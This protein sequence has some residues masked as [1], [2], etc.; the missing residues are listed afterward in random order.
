ML[1]FKY[2][3]IQ[4]LFMIFKS[5]LN[6]K[7]ILFTLLIFFII[8]IAFVS[9]S[10]AFSGAGSGTTGDP[11]QITDRAQLE[12]ISDNLSASYILMNDIDLGGSATPW[13]SISGSFS[14]IIDGNGMSI[15]N[16][17]SNTGG[18][19]V[20]VS[21]N[22]INLALINIEILSSSHNI[23]GI[24]NSPNGGIFENC[25]VIG[26]LSS[27]YIESMPMAGGIC[28]STEIGNVTINNCWTNVDINGY[29]CG[30]LLGSEGWG[31]PAIISNCYALGNIS[32]GNSGGAPGNGG[33]I[34]RADVNGITVSN[35]VSL[36]TSSSAT[37]TDTIGRIGYKVEPAAFTNNY[38]S[39]IQLV[40]GVL[41]SSSDATSNNG[42]DVTPLQ[43]ATKSWW[44]TNPGWS[45]DDNSSWYWN[46][47]SNLPDLRIFGH[48]PQIITFPVSPTVDTILLTGINY[49]F[50][51][52]TIYADTFLWDFGD[53]IT[54]SDEN[55]SH[56]YNNVGNYNVTLTVSN[57]IGNAIAYHIYAVID[58]S[59]ITNQ[60]ATLLQTEQVTLNTYSTQRYNPYQQYALT[61]NVLDIKYTTSSDA[62]FVSGTTPYYLDAKTGIITP[63]SNYV[64]TTAELCYID[65]YGIAIYDT[66][67]VISYYSYAT[68]SRQIIAVVDNVRNVT[69]GKTF[70]PDAIV[71]AYTTDINTYYY[72]LDTGITYTSSS[73][74][75]GIVGS[76]SAKTFLSWNNTNPSNITITNLVYTTL[77][78]NSTNQIALTAGTTI[79]SIQS[80]R[81][82]DNFIVRTTDKIFV[83]E[84]PT[85]NLISTSAGGMP[86]FS[87]VR[88]DQQLEYMGLNETSAYFVN[89]VG[90]LVTYYTGIAQLNTLAISSES[91]IWSAF[92]GDDMRLT[93]L[94]RSSP[95]TWN[96]SEQIYFS[97]SINKVVL[98]TGGYYLTVVSDG[99]LYLLSQATP[100]SSDT[101]LTTKYYLQVYLIDGGQ[102]LGNTRFTVAIGANAPVTYT[103]DSSGSAVVEVVPTRTYTIAFYDGS[104]LT[105]YTANNYALQYLI[106]SK[107][108]GIPFVNGI[109]Y[110]VSLDYKTVYMTYTDTDLRNNMVNFTISNV[111][112]VLQTYESV[113][114]SVSY[115]YDATSISDNYIG[116]TMHISNTASDYTLE[117]TYTFWLK[118]YADPTNQSGLILPG[119]SKPLIPEAFWNSETG[120]PI[121]LD[122]ELI[123]LIACGILMVI[124]G[125]FG[126][127]YSTKGALL[128][129]GIAAL[130]TV[131]GIITIDSIWVATMVVIAIMTLFAYARDYD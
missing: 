78:E 90:T 30:A 120:I 125:L 100:D 94:G 49:N 103:T 10:L 2:T 50:S 70:L 59:A 14:G 38:G 131:M 66:E 81:N 25:S 7:S 39:T 84:A 124:A 93:I 83:I 110:N 87:E 42:I 126:V 96:L 40:N 127:Q 27:S 21:G 37:G 107:S 31:H 61:S 108:S 123:Q 98:S 17:Y 95:T 130:F 32:G 29:Q 97:A 34:G 13:I 20:S 109:S 119:A 51:A 16:L 71:I 5:K 22:V 121:K 77:V 52:E 56:I 128:V 112:S 33:I 69:L 6:K 86:W 101:I 99:S 46:T 68:Q 80:I 48:S 63:V 3:D 4:F 89:D 26:S 91:G 18:L 73:V 1:S 85:F 111:T 36:L 92:G 117:K 106:L 102:Y 67:K 43:W 28:G 9:P 88:A 118:T 62:Y 45:F 23:G 24:C 72:R 104:A 60:T 76:S 54:S 55:T 65:E 122:S 47:S 57:E 41:V 82:T 44:E 113:T 115:V 12:E 58:P 116:V 79:Q 74:W 19:F 105:T 75:D 53:G 129:A 35:T 15:S 11:Y 114:N 8:G 64:G